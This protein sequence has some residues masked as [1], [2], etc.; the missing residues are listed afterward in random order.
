MSFIRRW[1]SESLGGNLSLQNYKLIVQYEGTR[2]QGWQRQGT[3]GNTLQ[4]KFEAILTKMSGNIVTVQASGRTDSG[5]HAYGQVVNFHIEKGRT[6]QEIMDYL[7][8]YL[9]EDVAVIAIEEVPDRFHS[10]LHAKNKTYLY[11]VLNSSVPHIFDRRYVYQVEHLIDI[12]AM[13]KAAEFLIG[14]HDFKAFTSTKK[15]KKSTVRT[16]ESIRIEKVGDEIQFQYQGNGFLYHMIRIMTG[17]LLEIG[18][19]ERG[20]SDIPVILE[21]GL[22]ERAGILLPAKG[23]TL[24]GVRY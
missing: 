13:K 20:V 24:I 3:T 2:Y 10:R 1:K 21:S 6:P 9:P 22:R 23:L 5:V 18:M 11:R 14:T 16:I 17:T 7:N 15:S 12:H 4:G 19:G 8:Q